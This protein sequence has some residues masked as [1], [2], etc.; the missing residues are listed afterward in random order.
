MHELV[1]MMLGHTL[2]THQTGPDGSV[3]NQVMLAEAKDLIKETYVAV[4]LD[5]KMEGMFGC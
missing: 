3:V 5:R 1:G 4:L 2:V